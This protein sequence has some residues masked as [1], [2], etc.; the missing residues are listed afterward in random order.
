MMTAPQSDAW[1]AAYVRFETPQQEV[2]KFVRRLRRLGAS[3]WSRDAAIVELFCGR[4]N[5]LHALEQ[6]GFTRLIGIDL[7]ARLVALYDGQAARCVADCR[8]LP[9]R[10][11][12]HEVA[13]VQGGLHH[14]PQLARD[15]PRVADEVWRILRPGGLFVVVEPWLTPFLQ[16]VHRVGCSPLGRRAWGRMDALATMIEH[17]RDTYAA[18]LGQPDLVTA[19]LSARFAPQTDRRRFGKLVFVGRRRTGHTPGR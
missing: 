8:L 13:I 6:L 9:L 2:Q 5:G 17:E 10:D 11:A 7:S 14:L 4:G 19:T 12:S 1:E 15:L 18:W 16:L 3:G